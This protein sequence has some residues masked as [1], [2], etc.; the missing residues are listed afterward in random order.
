MRMQ[1]DSDEYPAII[2]AYGSRE[3]WRRGKR[4]RDDDKPAVVY[5]NGD[6]EW[7]QDGQRHRE[8]PVGDDI[9]IWSVDSR[10]IGAAVRTG[11]R[12]PMGQPARPALARQGHPKASRSGE[13]SGAK[14]HAHS[15]RHGVRAVP[16]DDAYP[17]VVLESVST[18]KWFHRGKLHRVGAPAVVIA[19]APWC[20]ARARSRNCEYCR[21]GTNYAEYWYRNGLL[22]RDDG[23][24]IV[25]SDGQ[26]VWYRD[27][28]N[29]AD[30]RSSR[31]GVM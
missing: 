17:A 24:A 20:T 18:R 23:P 16:A 9:P 5:A 27:G 10:D 12:H 2:R 15:S 6:M 25:R 7:W 26:R 4:H 3:W 8:P 14:Q 28:K 30:G 11:Q 31:C 29:P 22:H 19:H 13:D 21:N 1:C